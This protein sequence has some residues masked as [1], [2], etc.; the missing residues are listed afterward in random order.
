LNLGKRSVRLMIWDTAGYVSLLPLLST[1]S[2]L[3][4]LLPFYTPAH[5]HHTHTHTHTHTLI[6]ICLQQAREIPCVGSHILS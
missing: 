2:S 4:S 3:C 6:L 1:P 5:P